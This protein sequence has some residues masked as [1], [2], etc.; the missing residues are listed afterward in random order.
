[1]RS[2]LTELNVDG[3]EVDRIQH[4]KGALV[5][6]IASHK[7]HTANSLRH[8]RVR[9]RA[10]RRARDVVLLARALRQLADAVNKARKVRRPAALNINIDPIQHGRAERARVARPP[11]EQVPDRVCESDGLGI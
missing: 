2:M 4:P 3:I 5:S 10:L 9:E 1:M 11:K 6:G 8:I 7:G